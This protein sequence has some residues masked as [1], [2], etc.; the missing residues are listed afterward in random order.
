[1]NVLVIDVIGNFISIFLSQSGEKKM[2]FN[3]ILPDELSH[4]FESKEITDCDLSA[5]AINEGPGSYTTLKVVCSI[6]KALCFSL[7]IPL[8]AYSIFEILN[9]KFLHSRKFKVTPLIISYFSFPK[10]NNSYDL[11]A[12]IYHGDSLSPVYKVRDISVFFDFFSNYNTK[13]LQV[14]QDVFFIGE[15]ISSLQED[16]FS[17]ECVLGQSKHNFF[18][19]K[20]GFGHEDIAWWVHLKCRKQCFKSLVSFVPCYQA[21]V[22]SKKI[23]TPF[24]AS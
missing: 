22:F 2:L 12:C 14:N 3:E 19:Q 5:L 13:D 15:N 10:P 23:F 4:V 20:V 16:V 1:M 17:S 7:K 21:E 24:L 8:I 9:A 11:A 18:Y 6:S